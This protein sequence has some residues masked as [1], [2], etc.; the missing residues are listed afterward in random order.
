MVIKVSI[1]VR[2]NQ[3]VSL[4]LIQ[5][6]IHMCFNSSKVQLEPR[7]MILNE[8]RCI[9]SI[10]VRY[11][12]NPL[13]PFLFC[14]QSAVSIPVRYNQNASRNFSVALISGFNSSKVQLELF[15][16][17]PCSSLFRVSIPVRY[18]QNVIGIGGR[19]TITFKFQ[20]Q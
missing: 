12:Q 8:Q 13:A 18:N 6:R 20:F 3:N 10:P 7:F 17:C 2:Y 11:N 15:P 9:V 4:H 19:K 14:V 5:K 1:P 16:L